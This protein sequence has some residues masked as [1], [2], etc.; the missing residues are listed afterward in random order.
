MN[1]FIRTLILA[2][3][4]LA[5]AGCSGTPVRSTSTAKSVPSHA[6]GYYLDDGPGDHPPADL[7]AIP[8]AVPKVEPLKAAANRPYTAL[9]KEY[10]P[11]L[12]ARDYKERGLASWYGRRYDH[13]PTSSGEVYDMYGMTAASPILP[14]P[15]Y[16]RVTNLKNGRSVIVRINDRG[17][18]HDGRIIDLSYTAAWKLDIL[19]GVTPVEVDGIDP[20]APDSPT[21]VATGS[22]APA[23]TASS[24]IETTALAPIQPGSDPVPVPTTAT[25]PAAGTYLQFGAFSSALG[26]DQVAQRI[27]EQVGTGLPGIR[28]VQSGNLIKVQMGPFASLAEAE[29]AAQQ[30]AKETGIRSYKVVR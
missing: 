30:V 22:D 29:Q 17:P 3:I 12:S 4:A 5:L 13:K 28:K 15:S 1:L 25:A 19:K 26:A 2:G 10:V 23:Q 24:G 8:D 21:I 20:G 9:G 27:Q 11:I 18:F 6:G 14:I 16:A 7:A